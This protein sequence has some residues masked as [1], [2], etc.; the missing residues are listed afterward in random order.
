M[1]VV[2]AMCATIPACGDD[3]SP[4]AS[5]RTTEELQGRLLT[6][7]DV[8]AGW[9]KA[10][11]VGDADFDDAG[12]LPCENTALDPTIRQRLR[13]VTGVQFE[14]ADRSSK[15]LIELAV[16]AEPDRLK[17]DLAAYFGAMDSCVGP[18]GTGAGAV[19]VAKLDLPKV[20]DQRA[21]YRGTASVGP[22]SV[23]LVRMATVRSGASAITLGLTEILSS[24]TA[25]PTVSD[26]DFGRLVQTATKKL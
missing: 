18:A 25:K 23:W 1:A 15:H 16:S 9:L 6:A 5:V 7:A 4:D 14:P 8:G 26:A 21:A 19:Q 17:A 11:A 13:P 12:A 20:G 24:P 2:M 10:A 22:D 3:G